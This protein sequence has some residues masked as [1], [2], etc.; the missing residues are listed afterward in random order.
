MSDRSTTLKSLLPHLLALVVMLLATAAYFAPSVFE[1]KRVKSNDINQSQGMQAEMWQYHDAEGEFPLWSNGMFGGMPT[2]QILYDTKS[3]M[4]PANKTLLLGNIMSKPWPPIFL[5][6]AGFYFLLITLRTDWRLAAPVSI[7]YGLAASHIDLVAAGH[8]TKLVAL[9]YV[10]PIVGSALLALRGRY[11]LGGGLFA[12]F[13]GCQVF[14]NHL[15]ITF[16]TFLVLLVLGVVHLIYA[17]RAGEAARVLKGA[18]VLLAA[19]LL[20]VATSAG[21]IWTTYEYTAETIRGESELTTKN[22]KAAGGTSDEDGL[23][24]YYIFRWS[25]GITET[26]NTLVPRFMGGSSTE[27]FIY[28]AKTGTLITDTETFRVLNTSE[29]AVQSLLTEPKNARV[30]EQFAQFQPYRGLQTTSNDIVNALIPKVPHYWGDQPFTEGPIY[31]GAVVWLLFFVGCFLV[32]GP[33]RAWLLVATVFTLMLAW[34][35]NLKF[36]NHFLVDY[37]PLFNKFRAVSMALG[38][39]QFLALFLGVLGLRE[40]FNETRPLAERRRG[41]LLGGA[42]VTGLILLTVVLSFTMDFLSVKESAA[43]LP[44]EL[45]NALAADRAALLRADAWRSLLF[46]GLGLGVLYTFVARKLGAVPVV[47]LVGMLALV[48]HWGIATRFLAYDDFQKYREFKGMFEPSEADNAILQDADPHY[49]VYDTSKGFSHALTSLHHKA[50]NGYHAAK[51]MR[52]SEYMQYLKNPNTHRHLHDQLNVRYFIT[53]EGPRRN[54]SALG[55][56]WFVDELRIVPDADAEYAAIADFEPGKTALLAR[57]YAE[58]LTDFR[59]RPD[60]NAK[61][62]LTSYHPD[63]LN[64]VYSAASDQFA[65]FSEVYYPPGKGWKVL[66]DGAPY[67]PFTKVNYLARGLKVPAGTHTLTMI[68]APRSYYTGETIALIASILVLLAALLGL[69]FHFRGRTGDLS[70][71]PLPTGTV[72]ATPTKPRRTKADPKPR[73]KPGR[74]KR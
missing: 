20:A 1:G 19:T 29:A 55:N 66:L 37:V 28:D 54:R 63:T 67:E 25:Y 4:E 74:R 47:V 23:S 58:G 15:Q 52:F 35:S 6:M 69:F 33:A 22:A 68:F 32:R 10:A 21:R 34:G 3:L 50:V 70:P 27:S 12:F 41:V 43:N 18:G 46:V 51:L 2:Y 61:I 45:R 42:V 56:A 38:V 60:P 5:M 59:P 40:V 72:T 36:F 14:A 48:D 31:L 9:A 8:M 17:A 65:V 30:R 16:Y 49:R 57:A 24:K 7:A 62:A 26:L 39:T 11:L 71:Q 53:P 73:K 44:A 13:V 64:Y